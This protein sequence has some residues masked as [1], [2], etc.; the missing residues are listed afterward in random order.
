MRRNWLGGSARSQRRLI[1][2]A[3]VRFALLTVRSDAN[4]YGARLL[5]LV[6]AVIESCVQ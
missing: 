3:M 6:F 2:R 5:A 4:L 1:I